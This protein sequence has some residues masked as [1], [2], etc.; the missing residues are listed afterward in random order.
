MG[1]GITYKV[2]NALFPLLLSLLSCENDPAEI[3][4]MRMNSKEIEEGRGIEATFSQS[5]KLK[6]ILKAPLMYRVKSDT[7]YTEFPNSIYVTFYNEQGGIDNILR[8]N[9]AQYLELLNKVYLRDSVVVYNTTDTLYAE[10]LWWDQN[11]ELFYTYRPVRVKTPTQN[12]IGTGIT[13]KSDFTKYSIIDP[14][15]DVAIPDNIN[16]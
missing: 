12:L 1:K 11:T 16:P 6:A 8:A 7:I 14:K 2:I 5:G 3:E 15:G 4:A 9:Y 13:A 10:D